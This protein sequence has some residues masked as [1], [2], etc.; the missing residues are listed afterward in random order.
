MVDCYHYWLM[1]SP[2]G[3]VSRGVCKRCG[4]EREFYNSPGAAGI[5]FKIIV[6]K[7][8]QLDRDFNA[9]LDNNI[10]YSDRGK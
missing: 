6:R 9:V 7:V 2:D 8:T 3:S 5:K 1:E 10:K 4:V